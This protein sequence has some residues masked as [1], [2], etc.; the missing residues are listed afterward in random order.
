MLPG[1]IA[2]FFAILIAGLVGEFPSG[3]LGCIMAAKF[4][5]TVNTKAI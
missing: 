2:K 5:W 3:F 1:K 4:I